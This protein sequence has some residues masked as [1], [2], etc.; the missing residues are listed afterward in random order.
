MNTAL[1]VTCGGIASAIA[2]AATNP[3]DV[4]RTRMQVQGDL[5]R[6][7][8]F[9]QHYTSVWQG[10]R[11]VTHEEGFMALQKGMGAVVI[12]Q[13]TQN[14]LRIGLYP[15]FR[16]GLESVFHGGQDLLRRAVMGADAS[17]A[18][19]ARRSASTGRTSGSGPD[20]HFLTCLAAGAMSG[21]VGSFCA[22]PF[23]LVK[24]RLQ[25][26]RSPAGQQQKMRGS[27]PTFG[28]AATA[29]TGELSSGSISTAAKTA[30][31]KTVKVDLTKTTGVQHHYRG[32]WDALHS[33]YTTGGGITALWHGSRTAM[34]RTMA[35]SSAQL[36]CYDYVSRMLIRFGNTYFPPPPP[37]TTAGGSKNSREHN[38]RSWTAKD[39][40]IHFT[41]AL[42]SSVAVVLCMNPFEVV[43][44][45]TYNHTAGH[46]A[47]SGSIRASIMEIYRA[48]GIRGCYKGAMPMFARFAPHTVITF[49]VYEY[50]KERVG[51]TPSSSSASSSATKQ[52]AIEST[53]THSLPP[54]PSPSSSSS[55]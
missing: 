29:A 24:T 12:W 15:V 47:Y 1:D 20:A 39:R 52:T 11:R 37:H 13:F 42:I 45:R 8:E 4:M 30:A 50:L 23:I 21:A 34:K 10:L 14:G 38:S 51:L 32:I 49:L 3:F 22:S 33:I 55:S 5:C 17:A 6:A 7:G 44:T 53:S 36:V 31:S 27:G 43:M 9:E 25:S 48:E 41:A 16:S 2:G 19:A 18:A 46:A 26:Q 35:G 40:R 54:P 28:T